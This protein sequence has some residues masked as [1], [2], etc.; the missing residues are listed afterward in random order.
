MTRKFV[1]CLFPD[2]ITKEKFEVKELKDI[3]QLTEMSQEV[4]TPMIFNFR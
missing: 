3:I 1:S 4:I 2:E